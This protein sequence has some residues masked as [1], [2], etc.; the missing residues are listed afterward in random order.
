MERST[1]K[2]MAIGGAL[3]ALFRY[4]APKVW[5]ATFGKPLRFAGIIFLIFGLNI[6]MAPWLNMNIND[7]ELRD[8]AS[9]YIKVS[10]SD[11]KDGVHIEVINT[12]SILSVKDFIITCG[13]NKSEYEGVI[14]PY[15]TSD[16]V[17]TAHGKCEVNYTPFKAKND[18]GKFIGLEDG[19]PEERKNQGIYHD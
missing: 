16:F 6:A 14:G 19:T 10:Q 5:R 13:D 2:A 4:I 8:M 15:K 9:H 18:R 3:G 1:L 7:G 12:S 11:E 17:E